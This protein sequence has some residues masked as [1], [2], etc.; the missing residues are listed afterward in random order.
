MEGEGEGQ[1]DIKEQR[2]CGRMWLRFIWLSSLLKRFIAVF[3][4]LVNAFADLFCY[5][6]TS[7][8]QAFFLR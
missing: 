4:D 5:H 8:N 6:S 2:R 7:N 3:F 1:L